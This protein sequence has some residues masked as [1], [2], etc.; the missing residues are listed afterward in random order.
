MAAL[1]NISP[2]H[3]DRQTW[4]EYV[5]AKWRIFE[6]QTA[7]DVAVTNEDLSSEPE[8]WPLKGWHWE[9][10]DVCSDEFMV[11]CGDTSI[12]VE[13]NRNAPVQ[14]YELCEITEVKLPGRHN[15]DNIMAAAAMATRIRN[16]AGTHSP[17]GDDVYGRGA[18]AGICGND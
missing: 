15:L 10:G 4:E 17:G 8:A 7:D 14:E 6:N 2:D 11:Y 9:F 18:S 3:G 13:F 1:L 5:A 16:R 12:V